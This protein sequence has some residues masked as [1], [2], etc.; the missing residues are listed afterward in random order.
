MVMLMTRL[1]V[2]LGP[3]QADA[4]DALAKELGVSKTHLLREGLR[5]L[6]T[7]VR[8]A[9]LGNAIGI[10]CGGGTA[11]RICGTWD[12]VRREGTAA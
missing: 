1:T 2:D 3:D 8:E 6:R 7:A 9:K 5:L 11:V 4:I 10:I 12:D